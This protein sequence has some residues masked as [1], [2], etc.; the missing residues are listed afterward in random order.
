MGKAGRLTRTDPVWLHCAGGKE[1]INSKDRT[2]FKQSEGR[3]KKRTFG[4]PAS[5]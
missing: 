2:D 5:N 1:K 3:K 4:K